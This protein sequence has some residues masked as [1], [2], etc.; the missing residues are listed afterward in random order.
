M[1]KTNRNWGE[2]AFLAGVII[3]VLAGLAATAL[4]A[5]TLAWLTVVLILLGIVV[6]LLNITEKQ[7]TPFLIASIA[8]M[9]GGIATFVGLDT[10]NLGTFA[11]GTFVDGILRN[12]VAFVAPAAIIVALKSV[13][14]LGTSNKV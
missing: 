1:A 8:L 10:I 11:L 4:D 3:A 12:I 2:W 9:A 6:G 14:T 13:Y 5:L 7:T